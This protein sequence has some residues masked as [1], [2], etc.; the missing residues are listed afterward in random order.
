MELRSI[1]KTLFGASG[2]DVG[3]KFQSS[4]E[5]LIFYVDKTESKAILAGDA[6]EW[7]T[8]QSV[9]LKMLEEQ[10][11]AE[12]IPNGFIVPSETVVRLDNWTNEI[13]KLP[14]HWDGDIEAVINGVTGKSNFSIDLKVSNHKGDFTHSYEVDGPL[15]KF[16]K[17]RQYILTNDQYRVFSSHKAHCHS[18]KS[19]YDN[20]LYL[21]QLQEC[22][23]SGCRIKLAHFDSLNV[24]VPDSVSV[25]AEFDEMGNLVLTPFMGQK[26]SHER[27]QKVLGQIAKDNKN[28]L[29][30][31]DEIILF[32]EDKL[33][34]VKEIISNRVI[35][36]DKVKDFLSK[37]TAYIDASLVDL[38]LGFSVRVHGATA[39]KHAYFGE[40]DE[41]GIDWFAKAA[42]TES[43][44]AV[45]KLKEYI[46]DKETLTTFE[47]D[48]NNAVK[49]GAAT[50]EFEEKEFDVS[51][52][53]SVEKTI[54]EISSS[55]LQPKKETTENE[56]DNVKGEVEP[57]D[58]GDE[59]LV[60]DIDLNDEDLGSFSPGVEASIDDVCTK[61][62]LVW[63]NYD[64]SP[65]PHQERGVRWIVGLMNSRT[66]GCGGLL[67]DDMG[68]GKTYMALSSADHYYKKMHAEGNTQKP[69]LIVAPLGL[70]E[71]WEDEV[72][73]TFSNSPFKDIVLLQ[74]NADLPNYREGGAEIRGSSAVEGDLSPRYSLKVGKNFL[75][76][77]LDM[78]GRLII[79]TYHTLRDYQFSLCLIDWGMVIFDEAQNIKNPNALQTRAAK[80]LKAEF[81]L[82]A[83]GTPVENSLV[84][85]WCLMDT[86]CPGFLGS[87]QEFREKFVRPILLSAG[88][89]VDEVR[90]RLGRE[91]RIKV[92][93]LML[94][95]LKDDNLDGL[96]EKKIYVGITGTSW[97]FK[98][99]LGKEMSGY[100][101]EV[102]DAAVATQLES[103]ESHVLSTLQRLRDSSL[104]PRLVDAGRL[105]VVKDKKSAKAVFNESGKLNALI[106]TLDLIE[107]NGEKCIIFCVNKRLQAFLSVSLGM[108]YRLDPLSV[109]NGDAKAVAKRK[110]VPTRKSM[111]A[112]FEEREGFNVI[113]MSP[114]AAGVGLT[115]IGANHVIHLERHWNPAKE[116][117]ATDRVYRIGQKRD[118]HI[119][120]PL[121][122]HP[123]VESFDVNLHRLLA[124]KTMLKDAVITPE[125]VLPNPGGFGDIEALVSNPITFDDC[126][127]L[128]WQQ[129]EALAVEL[130]TRELGAGN[131]WLTK[132]GNDF[133]ADGVLVTG[134]QIVLIQVKHT[135]GKYDGYKAIQE[136][137]GA[138]PVYES[139]MKKTVRGLYFLTNATK[140]S[141]RTRTIGED[142]SV[143]ICAGA[144]LAELIQ[145]HHISYKEILSRLDKPRFVA[146]S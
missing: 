17:T 109:I 60:V 92:G 117:Q 33:K 79:T 137:V 77:R 130:L 26:S 29:K 110:S 3:Y 49:T 116:A 144:E 105:E 70:L 83:T 20:L 16:S 106:S 86:A 30:V 11:E 123:E 43:I 56:A 118:V 52:R 119:Y 18:K 136:V 121:L 100:Q 115:V 19:E 84:D 120:L 41:S 142:C 78:P 25:E 81:K 93:A 35:P 132:S 65:Y 140:L 128:S 96:P 15:L 58:G 7:V 39:F 66:G 62:E 98:P 125:G 2:H 112:D 104:H 37:P 12:G 38:D 90:A 9:T 111:I 63:N 114:I 53:Q 102:Y 55:L 45:T 91:L 89:E 42:S 72:D 139:S 1:V 59:V 131:A 8:A 126:L 101:L 97:E 47:C 75:A 134:D 57:G 22:K 13:L 6:G 48:F 103:D 95:R 44:F 76:D 71:V 129:F 135:G 64:R 145:R 68:L 85:F 34:A 36:K 133:G 32:D 122:L 87:Y 143:E 14:Q 54:S 4:P 146:G 31:G 40:K 28:T 23:K 21:N 141:T 69:I 94:R 27:I 61:E 73:K 124:A 74:A 138:K 5:G 80:G 99:E 127:K 113:I 24:N 67:A 10:G 51:D 46:K 82:V 107:R 88:D 50:V 108:L